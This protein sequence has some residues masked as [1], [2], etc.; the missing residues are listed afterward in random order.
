M[1]NML[2]TAFILLVASAG[3]QS[4]R[5]VNRKI[6]ENYS[7]DFSAHTRP[8]AYTT[9]GNAL[10]LTNKVKLNPAVPDRGGAYKCDG[11]IDDKE[12]EIEFEFT[13]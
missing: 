6:Y 13:V 4:G 12:F 1:K 11:T 10:E 7:F 5:T 9:V 2:T 3:A 8:I